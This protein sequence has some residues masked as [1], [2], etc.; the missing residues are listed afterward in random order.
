MVKKKMKN[1]ALEA[2][3]IPRE[4]IDLSFLIPAK[5]CIHW[6]GKLENLKGQK[7]QIATSKATS[8][9]HNEKI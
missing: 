5:L 9:P 4:N 8:G 3:K 6:F 1:M 2:Q 7:I